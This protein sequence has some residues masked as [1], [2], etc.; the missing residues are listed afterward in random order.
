MTK[1]TRQELDEERSRFFLIIIIVFLVVVIFITTIMDRNSMIDLEQ[2][3]QSCQENVEVWTLIYNCDWSN[4][5][6]NFTAYY[7]FIDYNKYQEQV[8]FANELGCEVIE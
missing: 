5:G 4:I 8:E 1:Q 2:E 6:T 3:L 7:E